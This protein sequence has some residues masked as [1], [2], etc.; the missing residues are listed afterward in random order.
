MGYCLGRGSRMFW[1]YKRTRWLHLGRNLFLESERYQYKRFIWWQLSI[2]YNLCH[3]FSLPSF[4]IFFLSSNF[5][6]FS[7]VTNLF[8][9]SFVAKTILSCSFIFFIFLLFFVCFSLPQQI[10]LLD[11]N[12]SGTEETH[13]SGVTWWS[14]K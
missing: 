10:V 5:H 12:F 9:C 6:H 13:F 14:I 4:L 7:L 1:K 2:F 11:G 8:T 3:F